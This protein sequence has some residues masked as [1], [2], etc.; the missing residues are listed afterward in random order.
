[1]TL[2]T[3]T[4]I[5]FIGNYSAFHLTKPVP[6]CNRSDANSAKPLK[7]TPINNTNRKNHKLVSS[8]P[9]P[10]T[11]NGNAAVL[12]SCHLQSPDRYQYTTST[13]RTHLQFHHFL[14]GIGELAYSQ[15]KKV[16]VKASHTHYQTNIT[17]T[18]WADVVKHS[19]LIPAGT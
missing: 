7:L 16:K 12:P 5:T 4:Q 3:H 17:T 15:P 8:F 9:D 1:M 11:P 18:P 6:I 2:K 13:V 10:M 14:L 19:I